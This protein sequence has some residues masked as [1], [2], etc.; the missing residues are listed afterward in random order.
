ML[1][2]KTKDLVKKVYLEDE[3]HVGEVIQLPFGQVAVYSTRSPEKTP[4]HQNEDAAGLFS[5]GDG[6]VVLAVADGVG[7][8]PKGSQASEVA[9]Q[10][11]EEAIDKG[12]KS[13]L[14]VRDAI[15]NGIEE[16][17]TRI[18]SLG[19]GSATTISIAEVSQDSIR[20]Y[21]VGDS[22]ILLFGLKGKT[23][24]QTVPHSPVG[25]LVEGGAMNEREALEAPDSNLISNMLGSQEMRIEIGPSIKL[26]QRDTL[27]LATDGLS[28]NFLM[29]EIIERARKGNLEEV[30][31]RLSAEVHQRMVSESGGH[32]S[33][34]DDCT[35]ILFRP[36]AA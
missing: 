3:M 31:N 34:P 26:G 25:Y 35:F 5:Y 1:F 33:K 30:M 6:T 29:D 24:W 16:A 10:A 21:H 7:G 32:P 17:N 15:L 11:L 9:M 13:G 19:Q 8:L 14:Q 2:W 18:L 20:P 12:Q 23:K 27:L 4:K 28:D 22:L 36:Q